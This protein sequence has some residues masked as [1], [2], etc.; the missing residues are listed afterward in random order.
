MMKILV[1]VC[2]IVI[3]LGAVQ[4]NAQV[5][6]NVSV[7]FDEAL[8][9]TQG[10]CA[11]V[12]AVQYLYVAANNFGMWMS[13]IEYKIVYPVQLSWVA[14]IIDEDYLSVGDS[15]LGIGVTFPIPAPAFDSFLVQRVFAL[16]NCDNCDGVPTSAGWPLTVVGH[17]S[18]GV[19]RGV[20]FGSNRVVEAIGMTSSICATTPIHDTTWGG[21][22]ALYE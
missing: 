13:G 18:S 7:Y 16:W 10:N 19:V 5:E 20:E 17:P 1:V 15:P 11:G 4:A 3:G 22:K 8:Q 9:Y 12:G 14:D 6:P 2:A 21:I